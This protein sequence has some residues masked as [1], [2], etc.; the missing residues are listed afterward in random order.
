[1][2]KIIQYFR[3]KPAALYYVVMWIV[4]VAPCIVLAIIY[5]LRGE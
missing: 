5:F 2:K 3:D 4:L 1:M